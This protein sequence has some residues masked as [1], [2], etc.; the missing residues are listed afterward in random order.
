M[1]AEPP[2]PAAGEARLAAARDGR[3]TAAAA[4]GAAVGEGHLAAR[5]TAVHGGPGRLRRPDGP[6]GRRRRGHPA[7]GRRRAAVHHHHRVR[8]LPP[9]PRRCSPPPAART[10]S[11]AGPAAPAAE[12]PPRWPRDWPRASWAATAA[13][14]SGSRPRPAG[15]SVSS[16]A[17]DGRAG[18]RHRRATGQNGG[19]HRPAAGRDGRQHPGRRRPA[20]RVLPGLR[21][22]PAARDPVLVR[23]YDSFVDALREAAGQLLADTDLHGAEEQRAIGRARHAPVEAIAAGNPD[24][25]VEA[26]RG[27]LDRPLDELRSPGRRNPARASS[28]AGR[29][30]RNDRIGRSLRNGPTR[31]PCSGCSHRGTARRGTRG[32]PRPPVPAGPCRS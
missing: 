26:T 23:L 21:V 32:T 19:G 7:G 8:L 15:R 18:P 14:R 3:G 2:A 16:R 27:N 13:A 28:R 17:G 31:S 4:R 29:P 20:R 22:V 6:G 1:R 10:T 30:L 11:P 25:A 9:A 12:R 24:A 5:G